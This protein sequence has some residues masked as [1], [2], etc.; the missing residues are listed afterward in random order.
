MVTMLPQ[1]SHIAKKRGVYYYRRRLPQPSTREL[2]LSLRTRSF[3]KAEWL[4]ARLD[5]AFHEV[6]ELV[7]YEKPS[8]IP[9]IARNYLRRKLDFDLEMRT[10][11][12]HIGVYS[13]SG[14]QGR[15]VE[16]DLE[17][18][19]GELAG[20]R[21]ELLERLYRHQRPLID[22]LAKDHSVPQDQ[23]N[24]LAHAILVANV[25][26]WE[27]V[28]ERTRGN[29][30]TIPPELEDNRAIAANGPAPATTQI[31][32]GPV[33]SEVLPGFL[34]FMADQDVW[35]GQTLAQNTA[36][37]R[38]F[39]ECCGDRPVTTYERKDLAAFFDLLRGLPKL[40]SKSAVWSGMALRE[41]ANITQSEEHER[42]SMKTMKRH[43]SALGRF[44]EYLRKC[45]EY[46][47]DNPA[48]GF[49]FPDK[50]RARDK[51]SMWNDE[52]IAQLFTTPVWT[53]CLSET[54]R[55]QPGHLI[56]KDE[57]YWLP[58]LGAFHG[59]RLEEFAQLCRGDLRQS[60]DIW[61]LDINDD[62]EKQVK[63]E[64]SKRRIPL[65]PEIQSLGFLQ[66]V[67]E[68]A[69]N[70]TDRVF[71]Q[72][73]PGGP[74]QK[75][76]YYFSKWFSQYR[77]AVGVYRRGLDYHSFRGAVASKLSAAGV[78]LELRNEL[79]GHEGGSVDERHYQKGFPLRLL[80]DAIAKVSWPELKLSGPARRAHPRDC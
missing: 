31:V 59:N 1:C 24:A 75:L 44:F 68:I 15:V 76:G 9:R 14:D 73:Q 38:M 16:D 28:I 32:A 43:F 72:L 35:R 77:R 12:P 10:D 18:I 6:I 30:T 34:K 36:T 37:Y 54:R 41:I 46:P 26:F 58:L 64:Q 23:W 48:H 62:D 39:T 13:R 55:S 27:T 49:E 22:E 50:Q 52:Q 56:L 4:A 42:L 80:A 2:T 33:L 40:Y 25:R 19:E 53:G 65:H 47:G 20:A 69:P 66:Y 45:G 70:P 5:A 71:P 67:F 11:S 79:L 21:T 61:Y 60:E 78:G 51:R 17:W 29:L 7:K 63:N 74:D 3:R 57:K 8:D